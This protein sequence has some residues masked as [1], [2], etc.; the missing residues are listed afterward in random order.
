MEEESDVSW[1][2]D[3]TIFLSV[4]SPWCAMKSEQVR[5]GGS[6]KVML[7]NVTSLL[8]IKIPSSSSSSVRV[9]SQTDLVMG[10]ES[11]GAIVRVVLN[12]MG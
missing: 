10:D 6:S 4:M 12:S 3:T 7:M 9:I 1:Y 2:P 8:I 11:C 5:E